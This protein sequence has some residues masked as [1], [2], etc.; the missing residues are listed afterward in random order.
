MASNPS[1]ATHQN[2]QQV[3]KTVLSFKEELLRTNKEE[4]KKIPVLLKNNTLIVPTLC[5]F[6][7]SSNQAQK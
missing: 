5:Y 4:L 1:L 3:W 7:K 6:R 2:V